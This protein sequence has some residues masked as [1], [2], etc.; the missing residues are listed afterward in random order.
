MALI[1][2][3]ENSVKRILNFIKIESE[4]KLGADHGANL[5]AD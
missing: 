3:L 5:D 2:P 1:P 4:P